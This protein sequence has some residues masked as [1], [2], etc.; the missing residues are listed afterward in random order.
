MKFELI[1]ID[2]RRYNTL[3]DIK[4]ISS[5]NGLSIDCKKV[6]DLSAKYSKI[7]IDKNSNELFATITRGKN[8]IILSQ[9]AEDKLLSIKVIS[10]KEVKENL[11]VDSILDKINDSGIKS[12]SAKEKIFLKR[13]S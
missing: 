4:K 6:S 13:K 1:S 8:D 9:N 7:F 3:E 2:L 12:L 10:T 5:D 11:S